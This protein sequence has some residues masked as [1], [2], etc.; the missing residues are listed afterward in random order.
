MFPTI[1]DTRKN[2]AGGGQPSPD[3]RKN[4]AGGG[5]PSQPP[6][7]QQQPKTLDSIIHKPAESHRSHDDDDA[8]G[9]EDKYPGARKACKFAISALNFDDSNTAVTQILSALHQLTG[10][11]YVPQ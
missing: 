6:Q 11:D 5:Q 2:N 3:T 10:K 7:P 8:F 4:N 9:T 1:P